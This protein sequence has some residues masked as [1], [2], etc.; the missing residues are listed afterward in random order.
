MNCF[1]VPLFFITILFVS[2][3]SA[4]SG[5][6]FKSEIFAQF[7]SL[8]DITYGEAMN[9]KGKTQTLKLDIFSPPQTD[10]L[11]YR[12]LLIF[13]HG[14]GFRNNTKVGAF[15]SRLC[16]NLAKRGYVA[17]SIDYRLG[18]QK[19]ES[20]TAYF[21]ALYRAVQDAKAAV[22]FFRRYA[23]RYGIDTNQ[24]FIMGSSAG[25]K[26]A[27]HLA[28]LDQ[29]EVPQYIDTQRLGTLEGN[30]GNAGY[31]SK[32]QGVINCW[33]AMIDDKWLQKGDVPLFN[34]AG[35]NDKTVPY[36][37]SFAYH[38]F[39]YGAFILF[40]KALELGIPTGYRPFLG[41]GHTLDNNVAKQDSAI[42]DVSQWLYT[43]L[44]HHGGNTE[45][46]LR[47]EKDI[48]KFEEL[49]KTATYSSNAILVTGSSYIRQ[50]TN[51]AADLAPHEVIP[52]GFGG[53]NIREMAYYVR[54]ITK[55]HPKVKA[56]VFYSGS[57]DLA[58]TP[59]DKTPQAILETFKYV[60]KTVRETH[61]NTPI[62]WIQISPNERRWSVQDKINETNRLFKEYAAQTPNLTIIEAASALLGTEKKPNTLLLKE[63]KLHL[64]DEGNRVWAKAIK[65]YLDKLK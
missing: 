1:K 48:Q 65:P 7:D 21:E 57:N 3:L 27:M 43:Q 14:G 42:A 15:S 46:V 16:S 33:G 11:K 50:W 37:S 13:I 53:S 9:V 40:Q 12:P 5:G 29:K 55:A 38:G 23:D 2:D 28:Y 59:K 22:R 18:I 10:T 44:H 63:D 19:P 62:F 56:I 49:D 52:R 54:R 31:S 17:S 20:D 25:S 8:T 64:T 6:R 45:G 58:A 60:L 51:I 34:I 4:Q 61:P 30:S 26:T 41:A 24:I 32:V 39:R 47:Y 36:D 35:T